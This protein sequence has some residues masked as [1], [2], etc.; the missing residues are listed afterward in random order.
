[1]HTSVAY[2]LTSVGMTRL[3]IFVVI[4]FDAFKYCAN[5]FLKARYEG[6]PGAIMCIISAG[7]SYLANEEYFHDCPIDKKNKSLAL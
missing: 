7:T 3:I 1:M 5:N 2:A 6:H 4:A